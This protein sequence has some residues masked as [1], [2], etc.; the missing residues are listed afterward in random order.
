M[1]NVSLCAVAR[2][3]GLGLFLTAGLLA[4]SEEKKEGQSC[5]ADSDCDRG[6]VCDDE[7]SRCQEVGC[8]SINDCPGSGRTCLADTRTCSAKECIPGSEDPG[9]PQCPAGQVCI[10]EGPNRA[11]CAGNVRCSDNTACGVLGEGFTCCGGTCERGCG[12]DVQGLLDDSTIPTPGDAQAGDTGGG[13]SAGDAG[14]QPDMG[15]PPPGEA[16]ICSECTGDA[17]CSALGDGAQCKS[18]EAG[19]YCTKSCEADADCPAPFVCKAGINLCLP[20]RVLCG[21][22]ATGCAAG[23]IC[24]PATTAC[25]APKAACAA[26]AADAECAAGLKCAALGGANYCLPECGNAC[27]PGTTCTDEV[28]KP[29]SGA[30]DPCLGACGGATPVCVPGANGGAG[31]CAACG[32]GV[33]CADPNLRCNENNQCVEP[34]PG[35]NC[36]TD[37]DCAGQRCVAGQCVECIEDRDCGVRRACNVNTFVCEDNPC[38]GLTCQSGSACDPATGRCAPGCNA[39]ADCGDAAAMFCDPATGQC[40]NRDGS[41]DD[42]SAVCGIGAMCQPL[43]PGFPPGTVPGNCTCV[44]SDPAA[45]MLPCQPGDQVVCPPGLYCSYFA[46][47]GQPPPANGTCGQD[48]FGICGP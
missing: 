11:S 34:A 19:Q 3:L 31:V 20:A 9:A 27:A 2:R 22:F 32:N 36:V 13:G 7:S 18:I 15:G 47:P 41:C 23:Q 28:C 46:F 30:C 42:V 6:T 12:A 8:S 21:C 10:A 16:H 45:Q 33:Q 1:K 5:S 4:C 14:P 40:F 26:C 38:G 37:N 35:M 43:I 44:I 29:D 39:D 17:D 25:I 48:L 24:D